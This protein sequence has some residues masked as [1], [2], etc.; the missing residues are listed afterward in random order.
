MKVILTLQTVEEINTD[1][2][3]ST[4]VINANAELMCTQLNV[5]PQTVVSE[6]IANFYMTNYYKGD[7]GDPGVG[8]PIGGTTSQ[9]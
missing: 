2:N 6:V 9:I 3:I 4:D 8:V 7:K 5:T 1:V